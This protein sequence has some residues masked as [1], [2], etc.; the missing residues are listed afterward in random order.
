MGLAERLATVSAQPSNSGCRTCHW[1]K[2]AAASD[3]AAFDDWIDA[4]HS[5]TQ[6][7]DICA[8]DPD[9]P[10]PISFTGFRHHI[11]HHIRGDA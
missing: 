1:L 11:R 4:G 3:R 5:L 2:S 9:R 8:T 10:L 7:W 6:L